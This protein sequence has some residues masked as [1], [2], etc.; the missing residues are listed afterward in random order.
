MSKGFSIEQIAYP[1]LT[2]P[3]IYELELQ[4]ILWTCSSHLIGYWL[5]AYLYFF[6]IIKKKYSELFVQLRKTIP[7][8]NGLDGLKDLY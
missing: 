8:F 3:V 7:S 5:I 4:S 1:E 2:Y 6:S